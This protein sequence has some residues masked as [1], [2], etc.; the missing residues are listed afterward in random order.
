MTSAALYLVETGFL[1]IWWLLRVIVAVVV[2]VVDHRVFIQIHRTARNDCSRKPKLSRDKESNYGIPIATVLKFQLVC[3]SANT[4]S[5]QEVFVHS[6]TASFQEFLFT[7][8]SFLYSWPARQITLRNTI[9]IEDL[10]E[11]QFSG[12]LEICCNF[13]GFY[14]L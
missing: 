8:L 2:I 3:Q 13:L 1:K 11:R 12:F 10:F 14:T 6:Q 9:L 4:D 5:L 7:V